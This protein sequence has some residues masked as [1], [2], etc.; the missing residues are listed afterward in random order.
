M[1]LDIAAAQRDHFSAAASVISFYATSAYARAV[2]RRTVSCAG[3]APRTLP[4]CSPDLNAMK[5]CARQVG[6]TRRGRTGI[7]VMP[8]SCATSG[9]SS[10]STE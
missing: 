1:Y 9:W 2:A 5:V 4:C 6:R 3:I 10:T 7:A 8:H